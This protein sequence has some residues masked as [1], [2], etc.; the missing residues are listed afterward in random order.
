MGFSEEQS[1]R[2]KRDRSGKLMDGGRAR[3]RARGRE[4]TADVDAK[5]GHRDRMKRVT[6]TH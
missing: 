1:L 3:R 4:R 6:L 5:G 2:A